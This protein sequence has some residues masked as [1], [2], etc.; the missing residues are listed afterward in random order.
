MRLVTVGNRVNTG[1][2]QRERRREVLQEAVN[3]YL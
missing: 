1:V 2:M 3:S